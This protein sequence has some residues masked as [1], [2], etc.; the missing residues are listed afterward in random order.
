MND[1]LFDHNPI[2]LD[3][4]LLPWVDI[5]KLDWSQLSRNANAIY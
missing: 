3:Y 5:T 2:L 4:E 1:F